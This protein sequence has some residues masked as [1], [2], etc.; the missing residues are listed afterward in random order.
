MAQLVEHRTF[1][2][3]G[4]KG[5]EGSSPSGYTIWVYSSMVELAA[6]NRKTKV[7]FLVGPLKYNDSKAHVEVALEQH[8]LLAKRGI[9]PSS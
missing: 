5:V 9:A 3:R 4:P 8:W 7:R 1:N 2:A 6:F